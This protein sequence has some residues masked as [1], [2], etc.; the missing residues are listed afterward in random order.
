MKAEELFN[1]IYNSFHEK[2]NSHAF[3]LETNNIDK[4]YSDV[5]NLI[6][7][8]NCKNH[9]DNCDC[10]ICHTIDN[11]TN[12]DIILINEDGK[13]IKKDQINNLMYVFETKPLVCDYQMYVINNAHKLNISSSNKILKF[14]EEPES[15]IVGFFITDKINE[16]IPTIRSRCEVFKVQ[17]G[18]N[19][20]LDVLNINEE[21]YGQCFNKAL[22]LI[23]NLEH[24]RKYEL[25]SNS[26]KISS[27]ERNEIDLL[28]SIVRK[29][30]ILK[31]ENI[32][33]NKYYDAEYVLNTIANIETEDINLLVNR[34]K[35]LDEIC[36]DFKYNVNK[37][38]F[39]NKLLLKWE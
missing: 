20:L 13:E 2:N 32:M 31:Y 15:N 29:I 36:N 35:L 8:V 21:E 34:I 1:L 10:N 30:Y 28:L 27:L 37:D 39:I 14:L 5:I 19:S 38:L 16:I 23:I 18:C 6:K 11:N 12:P 24:Q 7:K 17:Y 33:Y 25:M 4:C 26:K 3:L 9:L 22:E